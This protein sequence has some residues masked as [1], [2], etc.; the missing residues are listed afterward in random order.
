M[1]YYPTFPQLPKHSNCIHL[2]I[3]L[4]MTMN[5]PPLFWTALE[6]SCQEIQPIETTQ[7]LQLQHTHGAG[8]GESHFILHNTSQN[9]Q[10]CCQT[11]NIPLCPSDH[12]EWRE[13]HKFSSVTLLKHM[14]LDGE[15][16][17]EQLKSQLYH[18]TWFEPI[19]PPKQQ[20]D[21]YSPAF[22][23]WMRTIH[24]YSLHI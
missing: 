2:N 19:E 24:L 5:L 12:S 23:P 15:S 3:T 21:V 14:E 9:S 10:R 8:N 1:L 4:C 7:C 18:K 11:Q 20:T 16:I 17:I 13:F 22:L 6:V